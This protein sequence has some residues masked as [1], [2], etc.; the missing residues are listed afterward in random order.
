VFIRPHDAHRDDVV[1]VERTH[2]VLIDEVGGVD[3]ALLVVLP[4][5]TG[6]ANPRQR[7]HEYNT[8]L[9]QQVQPF[10]E[11]FEQ[12]SADRVDAGR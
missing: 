11:R 3:G 4:H 5:G 8:V 6:H 12:Q 7:P 10:V 2:Q 1:D 9:A